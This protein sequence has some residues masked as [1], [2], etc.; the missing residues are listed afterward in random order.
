MTEAEIRSLAESLVAT[1]RPRLDLLDWRIAVSVTADVERPR[2]AETK[3]GWHTKQALIRVPPDY[4]ERAHGEYGEAL[5]GRS[6]E[7]ILEESIVH[8]LLH[9]VGYPLTDGFEKELE[10]LV[11]R[12]GQGGIVGAPLQTAWSNYQEWWINHLARVLLRA[13]RTGGWRAP[14]GG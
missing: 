1:W 8:E 6:D 7:D 13:E 9:L 11:G 14:D 12:E 10:W 5:P 3:C 4:A 2:G